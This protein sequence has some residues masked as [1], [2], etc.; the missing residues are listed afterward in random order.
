MLLIPGGFGAGPYLPPDYK[1]WD[2]A[3]QPYVDYV[4]GVFP[5]L[6][7]LFTIC[8]GSGIAARAGVLDGHKATT[9]KTS[10]RGG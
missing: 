7:Y 8:T 9:N 3:V 10:L 6:Q 5:K 1:V 4:A 2:P